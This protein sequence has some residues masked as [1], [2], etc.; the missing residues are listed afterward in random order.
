MRHKLIACV[1]CLCSMLALADDYYLLIQYERQQAY[2]AAIDYVSILEHKNTDYDLVIARIYVQQQKNMQAEQLLK[3]VIAT[4]PQSIDAYLLLTGLLTMRADYYQALQYTA[5]GLIINP[6]ELSLYSKKYYLMDMLRQTTVPFKA[7]GPKSVSQA[8]VKWLGKLTDYPRA[9]AI[10][11][12]NAYLR[13]YPKVGDVA[14]EL[15]ELLLDGGV[16]LGRELDRVD[17][18]D[19]LEARDAL[20]QGRG[21][22]GL[23]VADEAPADVGGHGGGLVQ[24]LLFDMY[25]YFF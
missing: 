10:Q 20:D 16:E 9:Q 11:M 17:R 25:I 22:V 2:Q 4:T 19:A 8:I 1:L 18:L 15:R 24:E 14:L 7:A 23:Q 6:L 5:M 12:G 21:L 3:Q 13:A